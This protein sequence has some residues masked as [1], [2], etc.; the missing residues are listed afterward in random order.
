MSGW[1]IWQEHI[2]LTVREQAEQRRW[3]VWWLAFVQATHQDRATV[4]FIEL[5][6]RMDRWSARDLE[7]A[8]RIVTLWEE[9][10]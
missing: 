9:R 1:A 8:R 3:F 7:F 5:V 2:F 10:C 4:A 6:L